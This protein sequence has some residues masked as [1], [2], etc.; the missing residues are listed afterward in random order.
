MKKKSHKIKKKKKKKKIENI[1]HFQDF[2][3][4]FSW[5]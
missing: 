5:V 4:N 2:E 3:R 1:G